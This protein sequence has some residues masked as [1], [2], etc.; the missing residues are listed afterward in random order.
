MKDEI[1]SPSSEHA[2]TQTQ[3]DP[4][5]AHLT[6]SQGSNLPRAWA[7][8][9]QEAASDAAKTTFGVWLA[10]RVYCSLIGGTLYAVLPGNFIGKAIQEVFK[11]AI[12]TCPN[13]F[14]S[15]SGVNGALAG[16][17]LRWDTAWY[18]EIAQH[19]YACYGSSAFLPLYPLLMRIAGI[20]FLGNDLA[21]ALVISSLASLVA[22]YLLYRLAQELTGSAAIAKGAVIALAVFPTSFFLM[23]GYTESLFLALAIGAY[24]AAR[25]G[26]WL[27]AGILAALATLTRLQGIVLLVPL[28]LELFL[29]QRQLLTRLRTWLALLLAPAALLCYMLFIRLS[30]GIAFPWEPLSSTQGVWHLAFGWPWEGIIRDMQAIFADPSSASLFSFK[31]LDPLC[32]LLF[33]GC[34]ML[35]FR[36]LNLSLAGFLLVMWVISVTKLNADGYTTSISRYM[37]ALFPA[38]IVL[39]IETA[40]WPKLARMG[41]AVASALLL[42]CYLFLFLIWWWVA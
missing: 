24:L 37:L 36:R 20:P 34:T 16:M 15:G 25:R 22:L 35:A 33:L 32:A 13:Y 12:P 8:L 4:S 11:G 18:L 31:L 29:A 14:F 17:W 38:F 1:L 3:V 28:C 26:F 9:R 41:F 5:S 30:E 21:A 23:A 40:R 10:L 27:S 42:S 7:W 2:Q 39:A 6:S 19:G